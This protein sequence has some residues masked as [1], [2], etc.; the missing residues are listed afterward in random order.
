MKRL[1]FPALLLV[2]ACTTVGPN[3]A[4]PPT[5]PAAEAA[6][7]ESAD[8]GAIN[9]AWWQQFGDPLLAELVER[10][11]AQSPTMAEAEARIAEARANRAEVTGERLPLL[12]AAGTASENRISEN[13]QFPAANIPNFPTEFSLLD[14][15]F[16]ASWEIDLWG[17][18]TRAIEAT[19][20]AIGAAEAGRD[21]AKVSLSAEIARN[22][23][24]LRLAQEKARVAGEV[25]AARVCIARLAALL[26]EAGEGN[27]IDSAN[28]AAEANAARLAVAQA[29][30]GAVA[31]AYRIAALLGEPPEALDERLLAPAP[32]P[33][34][35]DAILVGVRSDLLRRRPDIRQ[36]ER[37]LAASSAEIGFATAELFPRFSLFGG[38]GLQSRSAGGLFE[39]SSLRYSI[40]PSFSW[41]IFDGGR[42]R[43][44]IAAADARNEAAAARYEGAVVHALADSETAIN[45]FLS[46]RRVEGDAR[47]SLDRQRAAFALSEMRFESGE[48]SRL[49]LERARLLLAGAEA[50]L[51]D[52][53]GAHTAAAIA[54]YKALGGAW[55]AEVALSEAN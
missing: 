49:A 43:A 10:A 18:S 29:E 20:A 36:A 21:A 3:Y 15:G 31:A 48:D 42:V 14:A 54:L 23:A 4:G 24:E 1:A 47:A 41:P 44:R 40:G 19:D 6:W 5:A 34:A 52:A 37:Q 22:Y 32:I 55:Q 12:R 39:G 16:D 53:E 27:A 46:A 7:A 11:L 13:G 26:V 8:T 35:P 45:R 9:P 2:S 51:A 50:R 25:A 30:T 17:R 33:P 28:A 38:L